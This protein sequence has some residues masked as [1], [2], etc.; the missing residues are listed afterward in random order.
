M[1]SDH[2]RKAEPGRARALLLIAGAVIMLGQLAGMALLASGQVD[3]A[4]RR[5]VQRQSRSA[6]F[7]RCLEEN[8]RAAAHK[9]RLQEQDTPTTLAVVEP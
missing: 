6:V 7:A 4:E 9:C 3:K 1:F 8:T 2:L 5:E